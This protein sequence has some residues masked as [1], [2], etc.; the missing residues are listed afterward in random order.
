MMNSG[1]DT[2]EKYNVDY[3]WPSDLIAIERRLPPEPGHK[4]W[5]TIEGKEY[6]IPGEVCDPIGK[7]WFWVEGDKPRPDEELLKQLQACRQ[8]GAN[9]LLDVGPD[10]HGLISDDYAQAL[11]RL[12]KNAGL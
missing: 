3:A 6:Y 9:F 8:R 5:R 7:D 12:A 4:K 1:I 10:R 2:G 11:V